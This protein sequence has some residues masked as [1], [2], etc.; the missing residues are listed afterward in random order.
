MDIFHAPVH[1]V[2]DTDWYLNNI[3]TVLQ[4]LSVNIREFAKAANSATIA[5]RRQLPLKTITCHQ[6]GHY[7]CDEGKYCEWTGI[8]H[9]CPHCNYCQEDGDATVANPLAIFDP[10]LHPQTGRLILTI[11]PVPTGSPKFPPGFPQH[12]PPPSGTS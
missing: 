2:H 4:L 8:L 6:C 1:L 7:H 9:T 3:D 12:P 10:C 5:L 11:P